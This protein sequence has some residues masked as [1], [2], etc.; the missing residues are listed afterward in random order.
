MGLWVVAH[1]IGSVDIDEVTNRYAKMLDKYVD[2]EK[3]PKIPARDLDKAAYTTRYNSVLVH[4][5]PNVTSCLV[6]FMGE[7]KDGIKLRFTEQMELA[8]SD[9]MSF[10]EKLV[11][12]TLAKRRSKSRIWTPR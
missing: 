1:I 4:L 5:V 10:I 3:L 8:S 2:P 9:R 6:T 7:T 12:Q 11:I